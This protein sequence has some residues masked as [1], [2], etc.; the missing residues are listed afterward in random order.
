MNDNDWDQLIAFTVFLPPET[1]EGMAERFGDAVLFPPTIRG[2]IADFPEVKDQRAKREGYPVFAG[3]GW[4]SLW[5]MRPSRIACNVARGLGRGDKEGDKHPVVCCT[6]GR[7]LEALWTPHHVYGFEG[8][9]RDDTVVNA[10]RF[11]NT[12][13]LVLAERHYHSTRHSVLDTDPVASWLR[14]IISKLYPSAARVLGS[15][16]GQPPGS[17][18]EDDINISVEMTGA[19]QRLVALREE[20]PAGSAPATFRWRE[21]Q[22]YGFWPV[23]SLSAT[24]PELPSIE[25]KKDMS[26]ET[27]SFPRQQSAL[28]TMAPTEQELIR[29]LPA[30]LQCIY[31]E[32]RKRVMAFG[33]HVIV[34]STRKNLV[35][36]VGKMFAEI[37]GRKVSLRILIRPEGFSI[38]ENTSARVYGVTVTRV[39]DSFRWTVNHRIEVDSSSPMDGVEKLLRQSYEAVVAEGEGRS[40]RLY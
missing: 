15:P 16:P 34:Y 24:P 11:S 31:L 9:R 30:E 8:L 4:Y 23:S 10:L 21:A 13:N 1:V 20:E 33:P 32:L 37:Q 38:P 39:P 40:R 26:R 28:S 14:Y 22:R 29:A 35:F 27:S 3:G 12:A 19:L 25:L 2:T 18:G 17:P 6:N 36:K 5:G 7:R